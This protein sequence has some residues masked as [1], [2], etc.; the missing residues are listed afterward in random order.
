MKMNS[1]EQKPQYDD[2]TIEIL[3]EDK[4]ESSKGG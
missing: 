4:K 1:P 2:E 3:L